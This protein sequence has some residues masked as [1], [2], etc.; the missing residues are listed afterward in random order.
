MCKEVYHTGPDDPRIADM[1][2]VLKLWMFNNWLGDQLDRAD[3]AKNLAYLIASFD[4]PEQVKKLLGEGEVHISTDEEFDESSQM[5]RNFSLQALQQQ[6][7][8][9]KRRRRLTVQPTSQQ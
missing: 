3:L 5:V 7:S 1:D 9:K 6:N 8:T 4:H 2:P